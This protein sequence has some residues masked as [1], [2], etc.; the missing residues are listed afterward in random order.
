M[1]SPNLSVECDL[2]KLHSK[3]LPYDGMGRQHEVTCRLLLVIGYGSVV[4]RSGV[5]LN[6]PSPGLLTEALISNMHSAY[7]LAFF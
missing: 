7:H 2:L 5:A 1:H 6:T 4:K 3:R